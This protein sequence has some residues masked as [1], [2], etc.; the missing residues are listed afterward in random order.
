MADELVSTA[1]VRWT[2][3]RGI[4]TF[5]RCRSAAL[6]RV[7]RLLQ[8]YGASNSPLLIS[9]RTGSGKELAAR[10]A[11]RNSSRAE[12][13]LVVVPCSL[14][15][16]PHRMRDELFD[17][18]ASILRESRGGTLLL[19]EVSALPMASQA[20]LLGL[21][22]EE[23]RTAGGTGETGLR[24]LATTNVNLEECVK[25]GTFR[26]D[27]LYRLRVLSIDVPP[28]NEHIEDLPVIAGDIV[29]ALSNGSARLS[30]EALEYLATLPWNGGVRE[31]VSVLEVAV[32]LSES[33]STID[34][35]S[36]IAP[37]KEPM[38]DQ[39]ANVGDARSAAPQGVEFCDST[40][41]PV[42]DRNEEDAAVTT[43]ATHPDEASAAGS[44]PP[45]PPPLPASRGAAQAASIDQPLPLPSDG[46]AEFWIP[47][48]DLKQLFEMAVAV[49]LARSNG[50]KHRAE[51][52]LGRATAYVINLFK[53]R[54]SPL[55]EVDAARWNLP[56]DHGE[57]Y[58]VVTA[59]ATRLDQALTG[60][61][62]VRVPGV[63]PA[64]PLS[65]TRATASAA[66][67]LALPLPPVEGPYWVPSWDMST[68][69]RMALVVA[70]ARSE[71]QQ[72]KACRLLGRSNGY[73]SVMQAKEGEAVP[74]F[75][76]ERWNL[77]VHLD[78]L[79]QAMLNE[80][81]RLGMKVTDRGG[82]RVLFDPRTASPDPSAA[83][84]PAPPPQPPAPIPEPESPADPPDVDGDAPG[85]EANAA[86]RGPDPD[87]PA[88]SPE[89]E[90]PADPPDVDGDTPGEEAAALPS[91]PPAPPARSGLPSRDERKALIL[92]RF[93]IH[94]FNV[95]VLLRLAIRRALTKNQGSEERAARELGWPVSSVRKRLEKDEK[96]RRPVR[97]D[98]PKLPTLSIRQLCALAYLASLEMTTDR[99]EQSLL[100][101]REEAWVFDAM[102]TFG[103]EIRRV[104]ISMGK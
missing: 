90:R 26:A 28:L 58:R 94:T 67:P 97:A 91:V 93:E 25:A 1:P 27:L 72:L 40:P 30:G 12:R 31:L 89:P 23:L 43:A 64:T 85:E 52:M 7:A 15:F 47:T 45:A 83:A 33:R 65:R 55:P 71:G 61:T 68:L 53:V 48:W 75:D 37:G 96:L 100:L 74:T 102:A 29:D 77:P 62:M 70:L 59:E 63:T 49:A 3:E 13:P 46:S 99:R 20:V 56:V 22:D 51:R 66:D 73:V 103:P 50:N 21:F 6:S 92:E 80:G 9:G 14:F 24:I 5:Q 41:A 4:A 35:D 16:D 54:S 82:F 2:I 81:A 95:P 8:L 32:L 86:P 10:I 60:T 36:I 87:P 18:P 44:D 57:L 19:D 104:Q 76:L 98:E 79:Q 69:R 101:G 84:P 17:S 78:Q 42:A 88:P 38:L 34:V 11:H 39:L